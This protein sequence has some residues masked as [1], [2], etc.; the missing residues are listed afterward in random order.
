MTFLFRQDAKIR[1]IPSV[2]LPLKIDV[3]RGGYETWVD[4]LAEGLRRRGFRIHIVRF[5]SPVASEDTLDCDL[6]RGSSDSTTLAE[7]RTLLG[8]LESFAREGEFGVFFSLSYPA[9]N[10]CAL[11]LRGSPFDVL[12][13]MHGAY[14]EVLEWAF[15]VA[16]RYMVAPSSALAN[17]CRKEL[18][19]R[20]GLLR[21]LGVVRKIVHGVPV[22]DLRA[23][24]PLE[25]SSTLRIA[26]ASRLDSDSKR[27]F[28]YLALALELKRREVRF[29]MSIAG[30]GP[31]AQEMARYSADHGLL[32]VVTFLGSLSRDDVASLFLLSDVF[33]STSSSEAF[34]LSVAEALGCGIPAVVY[35][36]PGEMQNLVT[37]STGRKVQV[38]D[39]SGMA[40][41]VVEVWRDD[42][43]RTRLGASAR[44]KIAA[45]Y[46]EERMV[47]NYAELI[48]SISVRVGANRNWRAPTALVE[49]PTGVPSV[50]ILDRYPIVPAG[51]RDT[52]RG[53]W[54]KIGL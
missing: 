34:G 29:Q 16:P 35:D 43:T 39:V 12:P 44:Q 51:I 24:D 28:D 45:E 13:V 30:D 48:R 52:V 18:R 38:G 33:V 5:S 36:I 14:R 26:V 49:A 40:D 21:S 6:A 9:V 41:V 8:H 15:A 46:S 53:V 47:G 37:S 10:V 42:F 25:F 3:P 50:G 27:P 54:R 2:I 32:D 1:S 19:D 20:V 22:R 23:Q 4:A 7:A 17:L 11:N 31:A